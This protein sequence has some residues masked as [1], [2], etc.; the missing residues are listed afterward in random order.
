MELM[1]RYRR[2]PFGEY[3]MPRYPLGE[4]EVAIDTVLGLECFKVVFEPSISPVATTIP[5]TLDYVN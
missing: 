4:A 2:I 3:V 1:L 5:M